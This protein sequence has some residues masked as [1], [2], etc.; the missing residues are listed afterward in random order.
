MATF[1]GISTESTGVSVSSEALSSHKLNFN[2]MVASSQFS[3]T[4]DSDVYTKELLDKILCLFEEELKVII[5]YVERK[6][7]LVQDFKK[8]KNKSIDKIKKEVYI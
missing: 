6:F 4:L 2:G 7:F 1:T 3:M 8:N 5:H